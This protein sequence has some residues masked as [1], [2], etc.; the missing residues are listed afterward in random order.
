MPKS[1]SKLLRANAAG[2]TLGQ[3][4][5]AMIVV[6]ETSS[7]LI[8]DTS[9]S[10]IFASVSSWNLIALPFTIKNYEGS[11]RKRN[12]KEKRREG[13]QGNKSKTASSLSYFQ[14]STA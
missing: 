2:T 8:Q 12:K 5:L 14:T 1:S 6:L 10:K 11:S 3:I 4:D 9:S 7:P 13:R